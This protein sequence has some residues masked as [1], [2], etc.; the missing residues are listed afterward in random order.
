V[1]RRHAAYYLALAE[2]AAAAL[3]GPEQGPW[4]DRLNRDH[5]NL[6]AALRCLL[7][8]GEADAALRMAVA[9]VRFWAV[10][11]HLTEG[12]RWLGEAL[13]ACRGTAPLWRAQALNGAG[14][15]AARQGDY[16][17]ARALHQEALAVGRELGDRV[18]VA[19]NLIGLGEVA[20]D[21]GEHDQAA[22]LLEEG[23]VRWR[24]LGHKRSFAD[25]LEAFAGLAGAQ[26]RPRRAARL[27]G[28]AAGLRDALGLPLPPA[29]RP[30]YERHEAAARAAPGDEVFVRTRAEG[31][32][33]T[34][35][36][37]VAYA[38]EDA[39]DAA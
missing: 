19:A 27:L 38:L 29:E 23:L 2:R 37:A 9:L 5:D 34:P 1:R 17:A 35:E 18:R 3:T 11:G 31:K 6:R 39:P 20:T 28:A 14:E 25:G 21:R 12:R 15:L 33:M 4:L 16:A 24:E 8:G 22:A 10:R 13:G 30:R 32:A 7:D 26:R 36:Q